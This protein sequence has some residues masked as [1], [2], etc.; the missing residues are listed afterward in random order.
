MCQLSRKNPLPVFDISPYLQWR[1]AQSG[2]W[3]ES[4]ADGIS[5]EVEWSGE[6]MEMDSGLRDLCCAV[7]KSLE[8][9]GALML[10]DPRCLAEPCDQFV[11]MMERYFEQEDRMK[12]TEARPELNYQVYLGSH[13]SRYPSLPGLPHHSSVRVSGRSHPRRHRGASQSVGRTHPCIHRGGG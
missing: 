9:T 8:E 5:T 1:A 3:R 11:T 6:D 12:A 4:A 7:A 10:R 2:P 13:F